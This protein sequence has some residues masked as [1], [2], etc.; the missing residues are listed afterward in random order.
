[1]DMC[2]SDCAINAQVADAEKYK[3]E[4]EKH[5]AKVGAKGK[6][7]QYVYGLRTTI[8]DP[9]L[10]DKLTD[11]DRSTIEKAM[12]DAQE[13]LS[14]H[15]GA[16]KEEFESKQKV[17]LCIHS[18]PRVQITAGRCGARPCKG[19]R[20]GWDS[21]GQQRILALDELQRA[22]GMHC[23]RW[24]DALALLDVGPACTYSLCLFYSCS[25]FLCAPLCR[26]S[27]ASASLW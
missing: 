13:W 1:M 12:K 15:E 22:G 23:A 18:A 21:G 16:E 17:S 11:D 9:K 27:R 8:D 7:E 3:E 2:A 5:Q 20:G 25:F 24:T 6:L 10:K 4:D 19:R 14:S 26:R